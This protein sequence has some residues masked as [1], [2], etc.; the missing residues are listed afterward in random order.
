MAAGSNQKLAIFAGAAIVLIVG[1]TVW[2]A[3]ERDRGV[4]APATGAPP[5]DARPA[6]DDAADAASRGAQGRPAT[7]SPSMA[8]GGDGA[9]SLLLGD[10]KDRER[11]RREYENL[12]QDLER[13]HT[14]QEVDAAWKGKTEASLATIAA[15]DSLQDSGIAPKGVRTDCRS[16]SC[17][18]SAEFGKPGDADDWATMFITMTGKEFRSVRYV[19]V[20]TA[21]G[22]T[23]VRI[24]GT[25]R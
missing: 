10:P 14:Q 13:A 4:A 9:R 23:E 2:N 5:A 11:A 21:D 1:V 17:R 18:V 6:V 12:A 20:P 7:P 15:N 25:R 19:T 22:G 24:Y 16:S 8:S 3:R